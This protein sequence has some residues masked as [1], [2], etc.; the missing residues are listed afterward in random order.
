MKS[1][2]TNSSKTKN[3]RFIVMDAPIIE[4]AIAF[5][6]DIMILR[7]TAMLPFEWRLNKFAELMEKEIGSSG[8]SASYSYLSI[9]PEISSQ[10]LY[11]V[12]GLSLACVLYFALMEFFLGQTFG[13][14]LLKIRVVPAIA[15]NSGR[16]KPERIG[17]LQALGRNIILFPVFP[18]VLFWIADP[19]FMLLRKDRRRL[20]EIITSTKTVKYQEY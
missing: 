1:R 17:I 3:K 2:K 6:T 7:F 15:G 19:L 18:I 4:R 10:I 8:F 16:D 20:T 14:M 9:H 13:K 11:L 5:F 12:S